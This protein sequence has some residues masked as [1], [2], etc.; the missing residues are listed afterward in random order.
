[1]INMDALKIAIFKGIY[2]YNYGQ[3]NVPKIISNYQCHPS[4]TSALNVYFLRIEFL[5]QSGVEVWSEFGKLVEVTCHG[6]IPA[7]RNSPQ[8]CQSD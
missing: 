5:C 1:M 4:T 8:P 2:R 6:M 3:I 7:V